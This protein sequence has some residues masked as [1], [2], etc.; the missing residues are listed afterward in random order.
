MYYINVLDYLLKVTALG[1]PD[2]DLQARME[3]VIHQT[4]RERRGHTSELSKETRELVEIA[5]TYKVRI[6]A[7]KFS[8]GSKSQL[9]VWLSKYGD[10]AKRSEN[11]IGSRQLRNIHGVY[12]Q[13]DL[14]RV[15]NAP[16]NGC[17][18]HTKCIKARDKI[19]ES[20][21]K[22]T[23]IFVSTPKNRRTG[24]T[25]GLDLTRSRRERNETARAENGPICLNP[26]ITHREDIDLAMR[27]FTGPDASALGPAFRDQDSEKDT[28]VLYLWTDGS[29]INSGRA[30]AVCASGV[31]SEDPTYRASFRPPGSPQSNNR[32]EIAAVV[33]ALQMAP[34]NRE[35][36]I[37]TDSTYVLKT[38]DKGHKKM[39]D[40][41]WLDTQNSDLI[42]AALYL[43]QI[44][45]AEPY[46]QKVKAHSGIRGN[47]EADTLAKEG[48][49][50]EIDPSVIIII[51]P[52]WDYSGARLQ[53]LTF[54]RMYRWIS[55]LNQE[56]KDTAAQSIVPEILSEVRE[57]HIQNVCYG[58]QRELPP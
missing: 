26:D 35:V 58:S 20:L 13:G 28:E 33:K 32:G 27:I 30:D 21:A 53:A 43:V 25:D 45:T 7:P 17:T 50:K 8:E 23:S 55:H 5:H 42:R 54:N 19:A 38:L 4:W 18:N 36:L 31:W 34:R 52:N 10:L 14:R 2:S 1:D 11:S 6:D 9:P 3:R 57:S 41:G 16:T 15:T 48:L 47:E 24:I 56:G 37:K 46:I 40:D 51:P 39:E 49:E 29:A 22:K 12:T 44:R